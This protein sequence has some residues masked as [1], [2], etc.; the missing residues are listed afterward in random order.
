MLT[1]AFHDEPTR[2]ADFTKV[3][4]YTGLFLLATNQHD[5]MRD[6][7]YQ[8]LLGVELL[9]RLRLQPVSTVYTG[10]MTDHISSLIVA[11]DLFMQGVEITT[12]ATRSTTVLGNAPPLCTFFASNHQRNVES[13]LRTAEALSWPLMD[14]MRHC[15]E[16]AYVDL[17]SG[18]S[19][20]SFDT[21]DW[22]FGL[23]MPGKY[24]RHRVM[25]TLVDTTPSIRSWGGAPFYD[26]GIVVKNKSYWPKRTVLGRVLGGLRNPKSV[27]GWIGP[28]PA[29][30]G[31]DA[32]GA[33]FQGWI[34]LN[35]RRLEIPTPVVKSATPLEALGFTNSD[36]NHQILDSIVNINEYIISP[37]PSVSPNQPKAIFKGIYL[38]PITQPRPN[39]ETSP[40]RTPGECRAS[41]DFEI[42]N[43]SVRYTLFTL[44]VFVTAPPCVGTHV[45]FRRQAQMRL[46]DA[47]LVKDL[48]DTNTAADRLLVINA[49]GEGDE[50][51]ARAW[52]AERGRHAVIRRD[53]PGRECC[54]ACACSLAA[55][56]T[57][58]NV[59]VL[60]WTK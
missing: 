55:G 23:V 45:Q 31:T 20:A 15:L 49:M 35:V 1:R 6:F 19:G 9:I 10:I 34:F 7:L 37:G 26:N 28:V 2:F 25:C 22:L 42:N 59:N 4:T 18:T 56:D 40:T 27:C 48:K 33:P 8:I 54:F 52:C 12:S 57:G 41:L 32:K 24:Y 3:R 38:E 60:I 17:A 53:V 16:T 36:T 5:K 29:P 30:S 14:E 21:Y 50:V 46:R 58:L 51:V 43:V 13:L 47:V 44:P 11:A 39:T